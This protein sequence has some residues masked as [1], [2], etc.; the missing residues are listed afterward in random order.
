MAELM[1]S[2]EKLL[3][4]HFRRQDERARK[5]LYIEQF[6]ISTGMKERCPILFVLSLFINLCYSG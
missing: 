3:G 6:F 2:L 4:E 1:A 5:Y